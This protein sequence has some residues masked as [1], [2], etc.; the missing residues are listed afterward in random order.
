MLTGY[1]GHQVHDYGTRLQGDS[2]NAT[3]FVFPVS[4]L[5]TSLLYELPAGSACKS[6]AITNHGRI[7]R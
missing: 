3:G 7:Y 4:W 6:A 2:A 5:N 1:R